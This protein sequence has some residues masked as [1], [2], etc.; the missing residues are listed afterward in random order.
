MKAR[1]DRERGVQAGSTIEDEAGV[2]EARLSAWGAQRPEE[3]RQRH[4][5]SPS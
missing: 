3:D 4:E 1:K 5:T 2:R